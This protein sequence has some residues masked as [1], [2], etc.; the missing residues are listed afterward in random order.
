[1]AVRTSADAAGDRIHGKGVHSPTRHR[2]AIF[3]PARGGTAEKCR[4]RRGMPE[5]PCGTTDDSEVLQ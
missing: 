5:Q 1:M 2:Y 4:L 3:T